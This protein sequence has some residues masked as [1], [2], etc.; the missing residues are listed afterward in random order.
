MAT[1][2]ASHCGFAE[3]RKRRVSWKR[4]SNN[5]G[6]QLRSSS[7]CKLPYLHLEFFN[8]FSSSCLNGADLLL[9]MPKKIGNQY[10]RNRLLKPLKTKKPGANKENPSTEKPSISKSD[11]QFSGNENLSGSISDGTSDD[12]GSILMPPPKRKQIPRSSIAPFKFN[13]RPQPISFSEDDKDESSLFFT[14]GLSESKTAI[15][16][17]TPQAEVSKPRSDNTSNSNRKVSGADDVSSFVSHTSDAVFVTEPA[18]KRK[19]NAASIC[20]PSKF[21]N[22]AASVTLTDGREKSNVNSMTNWKTK[23]QTANLTFPALKKLVNRQNLS[24]L[25]A[26]AVSRAPDDGSDEDI[27][28]HARMNKKKSVSWTLR[29]PEEDRLENSHTWSMMPSVVLERMRSPTLQDLSFNTETTTMASLQKGTVRGRTSSAQ[30]TESLHNITAEADG[31]NAGATANTSSM[32]NGISLNQSTGKCVGFQLP[33]TSSEKVRNYEFESSDDDII[34]TELNPMV[35]GTMYEQEDE[36]SKASTSQTLK[37]E[38]SYEDETDSDTM[39]I[40]DKTTPVLKQSTP[41]VFKQSEESLFD[42]I[43]KEMEIK[44]ELIIPNLDNVPEGLRR[45]KRIR[46][47]RLNHLNC[48]RICYRSASHG[49][50]TIDHLQLRPPKP[51]PKKR[52]RQRKQQG[53]KDSPKSDVL[54]IPHDRLTTDDGSRRMVIN[55]ETKQE[56]YMDCFASEESAIFI[57]STGEPATDDDQVITATNIQ[58]DRVSMGYVKLRGNATKPVERVQNN[59]LTFC[60]MKG[61]VLACVHKDGAILSTGDHFFVPAGNTYGIKNCTNEEAE[62]S[63]CQ[64][65]CH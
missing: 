48:E 65:N 39:W 22:K 4:S 44:K 45:S 47:P 62:L 5:F 19:A 9:V 26:A 63:F 34:V 20:A 24:N 35:P 37:V 25:T 17:L 31:E 56:V 53:K 16:N 49:L 55:P 61:T 14:S 59:S 64:Q 7:Y 46:V 60:V 29:T 2:F 23:T 1:A 11:E 57:S 28:E 33:N 18:P 3:F 6:A 42:D 36:I 21:K 27:S 32:R 50:F 43:R 15:A 58:G 52:V 12:T 8:R 40:A 30:D 10:F 54:N 13:N 38:S 51:T 41:Y